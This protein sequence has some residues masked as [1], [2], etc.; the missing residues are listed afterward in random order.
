MNSDGVAHVLID[1]AG[2]IDPENH[3]N[4]TS[5]KAVNEPPALKYCVERSDAM[6][7]WERSVDPRVLASGLLV[8]RLVSAARASAS[9]FRGSDKRGGAACSAFGKPQSCGTRNFTI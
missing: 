8:S 4:V 7:Y 5:P 3:Q 9:T 6:S 2:A 1:T